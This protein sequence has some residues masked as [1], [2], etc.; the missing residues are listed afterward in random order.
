MQSI[1]AILLPVFGLILAGFSCR[2]RGIL[3]AASATELNRFVVWLAL[4]ALLFTAMARTPAE[5]LYQPGFAAAFGLAS[6]ATYAAVLLWRRRSGR[7]L[8]DASVDAISASYSNT[9]FVG[10]PLGLLAFGPQSLWAST[11]SSVIVVCVLFAVAVVAIEIGLQ[12]ESR[13]WPLAKKVGRSIV[14]NPLVI[15]PVLGVAVSVAGWHLPK[16]LESFLQLLG[17]AASPCALV[18]LGLFLGEKR[19]PAPVRE[20]G[21]WQLVAIKLVVLPLLTWWLAAIAFSLPPLATRM[22]VLMAALP[23]GTGPFML[24]EFYGREA[25]LSSKATLWSTILSLV[26]LTVLLAS[27]ARP[28]AS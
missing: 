8:A 4:P 17:G 5:V 1:L 13:G 28:I 3:G 10:I 21:A 6:I 14:A 11:L 16:A 2:R 7:P 18:A 9:G 20:H 22:A 24:A 25:A 19:A 12:S 26:T 27:V 23:T 15:A